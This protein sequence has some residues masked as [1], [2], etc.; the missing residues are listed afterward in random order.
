MGCIEQHRS[1]H[2]FP[3]RRCD[4]SFWHANAV[5][6][7]VSEL[8]IHYGPGYRVYYKQRGSEL[9]IWWPKATRGPNPGI[10]KSHCISAR[11]FPIHFDHE[12]NKTT[13]YDIAEHLRTTEEMAIYLEACIEEGGKDAGFIAKALGDIARAK[14]M[15]QVAREPLQ[16]AFGGSQS[17]L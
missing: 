3:E 6:E 11:T 15:T 4:Q 7:G 12:K 17:C 10:S 2:I 14:G 5:C 8:R 16:S 13:R 9:V 1:L